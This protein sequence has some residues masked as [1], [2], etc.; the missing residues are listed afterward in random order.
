MDADETYR[1]K[2][3][4]NCTKMLRAILNKSW[5][6]H[7]TKQQLYG[8]LPPI[9]KTIQIRRTRYARRCGRSKDELIS[10]DI[11][12]T[13]WHGCANVGRPRRTYLQQLSTDTGCCLEYLLGWMDNRDEWWEKVR[14]ICASCTIWWWWWWYVCIYINVII[15]VYVCIYM[16]M[17]IYESKINFKVCVKG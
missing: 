6:Q 2:L 8:Y 10:D 14:E 5:K 15:D 1:E 9:F 13:P 7:P 17:F 16:Y 11:L 12:W 3:Y 4:G